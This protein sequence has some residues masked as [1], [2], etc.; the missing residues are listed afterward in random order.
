MKISISLIFLL[1]NFNLYAQVLS[2][3]RSTDWTIAGL[4]DTSTLNFIHYDFQSYGGLGDG[5]T[6]NDLVLDS[7]LSLITNGAVIDFP[8]GDF[9]FNS[10]IT[11]SNNIVLRGDGA[12]S[13][14]IKL[15]LGGTSH[16]II[17]HGTQISSDTS[18]FSNS[19]TKDSNFIE[20]IDASSFNIGDWIR[21]IQDDGSFVTSSW[22]N[23]TVGQIV[24]ITAITN[25]II[26]F[27]SPLRLNYNITLNPYIKKINSIRNVGIEC[28]KIIRIDSKAE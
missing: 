7:I 14:T 13:T 21:I 28:L 27:A 18:S 16:G 24:Q 15:D 8:G 20:I 4:N 1:I 23:G 17:I 12:E 22:A 9:L 26:Y 2:S 6:P 3:V 11:L 10:P 19:A 5:I 25:N